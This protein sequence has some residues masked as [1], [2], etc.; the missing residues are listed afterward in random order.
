MAFYFG[1][2]GLTWDD[3][4]RWREMYQAWHRAVTCRVIT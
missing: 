4:L 1:P 2:F 3:V